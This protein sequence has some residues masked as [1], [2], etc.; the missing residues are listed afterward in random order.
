MKVVRKIQGVLAACL[1][2]LNCYLASAGDSYESLKPLLDKYAYLEAAFSEGISYKDFT[3]ELINVKA[4]YNKIRLRTSSDAKLKELMEQCL[5]PGEALD[6][7]KYFWDTKIQ[8]SQLEGGNYYGMYPKAND[9]IKTWI[10]K[11]PQLERALNSYSLK[12]HPEFKLDDDDVN[13]FSI[14]QAMEIM[15]SVSAS[16]MKSA[17]MAASK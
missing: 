15:M 13:R 2:S 17:R 5:K 12:Q 8:Y 6:L 11:Y 1:L 14:K 9:E 16:E 7:L 3:S 4:E 10:K